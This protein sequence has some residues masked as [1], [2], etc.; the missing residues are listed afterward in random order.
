MQDRFL[1][2]IGVF[3]RIVISPTRRYCY[4]A[5]KIGWLDFKPFHGLLETTSG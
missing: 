1:C 5:R 4:F 2:R 3:T